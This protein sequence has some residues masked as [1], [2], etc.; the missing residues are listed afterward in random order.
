[1]VD[2]QS[3]PIREQLLTDMQRLLVEDSGRMASALL[4]DDCDQPLGE[5]RRRNES[6]LLADNTRS[7]RTAAVGLLADGGGGT[8][9]GL[10]ADIG[11]SLRTAAVGR[12]WL[13]A[14]SS[15]WPLSGR[16][17]SQQISAAFGGRW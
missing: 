1:M 17:R 9:F 13:L 15:G 4:V 7:L 10:S 5:W 8:A 2:S 12:W 11:G 16:R 3:W 6:I 14:D